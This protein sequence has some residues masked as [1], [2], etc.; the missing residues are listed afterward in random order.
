VFPPLYGTGGHLQWIDNGPPKTVS[1]PVNDAR[2]Y[3]VMK[4]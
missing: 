1:P 2:F 4:Y 3:R